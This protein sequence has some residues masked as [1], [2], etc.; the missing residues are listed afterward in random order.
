MKRHIWLVLG[1]A[2]CGYADIHHMNLFTPYDYI[3]RP[4]NPVFGCWQTTVAEEAT[5]QEESFQA[6]DP[7]EC[8]GNAF[9]RPACLLQLYQNEQ[10]A[11]AALKRSRD[12]SDQNALAQEFNMHDD[13]GEHGRFSVNADLDVHN[14]LLSTYRHFENGIS[15]SLHLPIIHME[16]NRLRFNE[17]NNN[18]TFE[19]RIDANLLDS[20]ESMSGLNL[21]SWQRSGVGDLAALVSWQRYFPQPKPLLRNVAINL[22][23]GV[24]FPT[25]EERDEDRVLGVPF[26]HDAGFG[27]LVAGN[28][29]LWI[30]PYFRYGLDTELIHH[31]GTTQ[32]RRIQ[33]DPAQTDLLFANKDYVFKEPGFIQHFTV[34]GKMQELISGLSARLSYQYTRQQEDKLFV[35]SDRY[36][37]TIVNDAESLQEWTT[38]SLVFDV[39]YTFRS[40]QYERFRPY[41]SAFVKHGFNGE[42]AVLVDSVGGQIGVDF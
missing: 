39:S 23:G 42:R 40:D 31:F 24:L 7:N 6:D 4:Q 11:L 25:G 9:S 14:I 20:V 10:N 27:G 33:T 34:Y 28:L 35:S 3:M 41:L 32:F 18:V 29:E 16:L 19:D 1:Y 26:G 15:C 36:N 30:G 22:R 37:P 12:G 38:H 13:T 5:V 8:M 17:Q 2:V 21:N